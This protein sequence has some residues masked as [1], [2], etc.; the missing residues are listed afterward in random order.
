[1]GLVCQDLLPYMTFNT[2]VGGVWVQPLQ[3]SYLALEDPASLAKSDT[4]GAACHAE[5]L[6]LRHEGLSL[7]RPSLAYFPI[8]PLSDDSVHTFMPH[9]FP[10]M[11]FGENPSL[12]M[13]LARHCRSVND[14]SCMLSCAQLI[15][16]VRS[17]HACLRSV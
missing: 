4:F 10:N 2:R 14:Q 8:R 16:G 9:H 15:A 1:M 12:A 11:G 13:F 6:S 7:C 5:G 17:V 3:G